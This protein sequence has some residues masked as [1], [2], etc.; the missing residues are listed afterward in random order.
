[1]RPGYAGRLVDEL[2]KSVLSCFVAHV[3]ETAD[4][5]KST[6]G[7]GASFTL[8]EEVAAKRSWRVVILRMRDGA[9]EV[10]RLPRTGEFEKT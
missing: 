7:A 6:F 3:G 9:S 1:M 8:E 10:R 2:T 4:V 5:D